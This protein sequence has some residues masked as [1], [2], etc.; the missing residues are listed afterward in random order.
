MN[1]TEAETAWMTGLFDGEGCIS[2]KHKN[3]VS[4]SIKMTDEDL[5]QRFH[6]LAGCGSL[7]YYDKADYKRMFVCEIGKGEDC[8]RLLLIMLP[9]FGKRRTAKAL[10]A[11]ERLKNNRGQ[12]NSPYSEQD[13]LNIRKLKEEGVS[14]R[15]INQMM[16]LNPGSIDSIYYG[17]TWKHLL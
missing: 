16:G 13:V 17:R 14:C 6:K 11:L 12:G 3:S 2:Y 1:L 7:Y 4:L 15:K 10:D 5:I 8:R 9:W